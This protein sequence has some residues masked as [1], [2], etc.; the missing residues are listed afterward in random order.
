MSLSESALFFLLE[1]TLLICTS[2]EAALGNGMSQ[3]KI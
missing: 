2:Q 3:V 1:N